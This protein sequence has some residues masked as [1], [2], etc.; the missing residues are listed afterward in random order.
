MIR[1]VRIQWSFPKTRDTHT[2]C[3]AFSSAS[4]TTCF[5]E[6][7]LSRL[8]FE[9]PTFLLRGDRSNRLRHRRGKSLSK[10]YFAM[11]SLQLTSFHPFEFLSF[12][13]IDVASLNQI[14]L[15]SYYIMMFCLQFTSLLTVC[16][17]LSV[18]QMRKEYRTW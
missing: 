9:H 13:I 3:R 16:N 14:F 4:V 15:I 1:G 11:H 17:F 18:Y 6:F 5:Y 12:M 10:L 8:R 2:Y 7:S